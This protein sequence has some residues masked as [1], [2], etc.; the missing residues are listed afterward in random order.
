MT[1]FRILR[2][3]VTLDYLSGL[4]VITKVL[5]KGRQEDVRK[6][7]GYDNRSRDKS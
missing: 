2:R 7:K 6:R 3:E 4:S 5:V 1:K